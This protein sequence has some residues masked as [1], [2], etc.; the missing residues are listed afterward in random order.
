VSRDAAGRT[1]LAIVERFIECLAD[2][3]DRIGEAGELLAPGAVFVEHPNAIS[4]RGSVRDRDA[5]LRSAREGR[6]MLARQ[7]YDVRAHH[8]DEDWVVMRT[9][10]TGV[11]ARSAGGLAAGTELRAHIAQFF[12]LDGGLIARI[13]SFDCYDPLGEPFA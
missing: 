6:M 7:R 8:V 12:L 2:P 13:E 3:S 9:T 1:S 4:P 5:M 10:W 11:L